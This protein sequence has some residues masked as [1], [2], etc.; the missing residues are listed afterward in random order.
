MANHGIQVA[1]RR[2]YAKPEPSDGVR[3]LVDRLWARGASKDAADL[4]AWMKDL[5]PSDELRTWFGH[6]P[7][8]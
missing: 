7:N 3:V 2:V 1:I 6:Q 5:G 4:D 8:R